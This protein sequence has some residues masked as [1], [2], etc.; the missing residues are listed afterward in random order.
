MKSILDP[1]F[2]YYSAA[3]TDVR[4]TFQRVKQRLLDERVGEQARPSQLAHQLRIV[5][6]AR[7]QQG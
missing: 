3:N 6:A 4:R 5:R 7:K 1:T 2:Q